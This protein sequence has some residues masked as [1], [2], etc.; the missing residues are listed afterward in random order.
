MKKTTS[1]IF[2]LALALTVLSCSKDDDAN[3]ITA[4]EATINAKM[5]IAS[6]D[7]ADIVEEQEASTYANSVSGK[8][9]QA[10]P[11]ILSTCATVTRV[12][13]LEPPLHRVQRSQKLL[14]LELLDVL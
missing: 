8:T 7:V 12:P 1:F 6:D 14:I 2:G 9:E 5:D 4:E 3:L 11:S 13:A 10:S